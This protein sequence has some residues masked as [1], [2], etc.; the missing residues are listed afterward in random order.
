MMRYDGLIVPGNPHHVAPSCQD[1]RNKVRN[2][3]F[4]EMIKKIHAMWQHRSPTPGIRDDQAALDQP[5]EN[6]PHFAS[7][8]PSSVGHS[9]PQKHL[10]AH[11]GHLEADL[12]HIT[13]VGLRIYSYGRKSIDR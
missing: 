12:E 5:W 9:A 6:R 8:T 2:F 1:P 13:L 10:E 3:F 11:L 7:S 4:R